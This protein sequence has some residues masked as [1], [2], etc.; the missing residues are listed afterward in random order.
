MR[1]FN[2][3]IMILGSVLIGIS[4]H[5]KSITIDLEEDYTILNQFFKMTCLSQ[6]YGYVLEG[7]KPLSIRNFLSLDSFP[8]SKD[9]ERDKAEFTKSILVHQAIP[10]WNKY[11]G[12]QKDFIL[13]VVA[14]DHQKS[15]CLTSVEVAF[16]NRAK[17][18][19][20]IEKNIDLFHYILGPSNTVQDLVSAITT[21]NLSLIDILNHDLTLV[22]I[23][24]GFGSHN[25]IVGGRHESICNLSIS[26]DHP[27]FMPQ[28]YLMQSQEE[29]SLDIF[30]PARYGNYYLEIAG[31][32][33]ANFRV[34]TP[35]LKP[36][37]KFSSLVDE[38]RSIDTLEDKI[39]DFL[40]TEPKFVFGAFKG[41]PSN[42]PLFDH[43][44][45]TQKK[46]LSL[47]KNTHFLKRI[48]EKIN[49]TPCQ[50]KIKKPALHTE[51][52]SELS[53]KTWD[54]ILQNVVN[55]FEETERKIA[56]AQAFESENDFP[57]PIMMGA[58][59][60][61]LK[62]LKIAQANLKKA[63]LLFNELTQDSSLKQIEKQQLFHKTIHS[64]NEHQLANENRVRIRYV[65]EDVDGNI[66][67]AHHDCWVNR[68]ELIQGFAHG[69]QDMHIHEEREIYVH[70][71]LGYGALTTLPPCLA[72]KI[73]VELLDI[74]IQSESAIL[75]L[76]PF[77]LSWIQDPSY[78]N[79]LEQSL[80][81][82]PYFCGTFYRKVLGKN[83]SFESLKKHAQ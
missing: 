10:L 58:S 55:R 5:A 14:L 69:M 49:K 1:I 13:K 66:L 48:L 79:S 43:L 60:A 64:G 73:K 65:I 17:L 50:I 22:G 21:T 47:V 53:Q 11:C 62:G 25:S 52:Y 83:I 20:V 27:P 42:Q 6:E 38:I 28:S 40:W 7:S 15:S 35:R 61:I 44:Q 75:G 23:V 36:H 41:G 77:D 80:I 76:T 34:E 57:P 19:Q 54:E 70:P 45:N 31:G 26:K 3:W 29:H 9:F 30:S 74:D 63:D 39:P 78:G 4:C 59:I 81:Q 12:Q 67:S 8:M 32:N 33:D 24:L 2:S 72:L 71:V 46:I 18:E 37:S 16:I 68:T 56:F 51:T 82:Q